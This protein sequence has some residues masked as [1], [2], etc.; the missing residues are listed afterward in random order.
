MAAC[1]L[2]PD[3]IDVVVHGDQEG[4][5]RG[6]LYY[7]KQNKVEADPYSDRMY[8]RESPEW[9][10]FLSAIVEDCDAAL[11]LKRGI[12]AR[13]DAIIEIVKQAGVQH[14][15]YDVAAQNPRK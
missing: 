7:A 11:I 3:E 1:G 15:L 12:C 13:T 5:D 4:A 2:R 14:Y 10:R 6:A 9:R 8:P